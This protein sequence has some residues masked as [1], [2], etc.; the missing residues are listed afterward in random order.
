MGAI[1][2][3]RES[4]KLTFGVDCI[5]FMCCGKVWVH[6]GTQPNIGPACLV[7]PT[8]KRDG[9]RERELEI[10]QQG[11]WGKARSRHILDSVPQAIRASCFMQTK[12][13]FVTSS[14]SPPGPHRHKV[15]SRRLAFDVLAE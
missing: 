11:S 10:L 13:K 6:S 8:D 12:H 3:Q 2:D 14:F 1:I 9:E 15:A 4:E 5:Q 7:G